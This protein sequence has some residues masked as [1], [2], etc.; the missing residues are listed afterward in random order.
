MERSK[1]TFD[2]LPDQDLGNIMTYIDAMDVISFFLK[3]LQDRCPGLEGN[4]SL[5][6]ETPI[7]TPIFML[8]EIG[9]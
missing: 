9:F 6:G 5:S 7:R 1:D 2:L 3:G 4:L 8:L